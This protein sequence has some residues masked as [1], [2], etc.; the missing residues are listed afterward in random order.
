MKGQL[1]SDL[2]TPK[3]QKPNPPTHPPTSIKKELRTVFE[4]YG[5]LDDTDGLALDAPKG[6]GF[7]LVRFL[8]VA[9]A[10]RAKETLPTGK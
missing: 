10:Q 9:A 4:A 1:S 8:H 2:P 6:K 3:P 5:P 7:V